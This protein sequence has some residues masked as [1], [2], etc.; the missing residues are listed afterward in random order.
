MVFLGAFLAGIVAKASV[1]CILPAAIGAALVSAAAQSINNYYDYDVDRK[2]GRKQRIPRMHILY[3]SLSLYVVGV[4][5]TV[6]ASVLHFAL[7]ALS[8]V[9]T[10]AYSA[11]LSRK[12]YWGNIVVAFFTAFVFV[13]AA[14]CGDVSRI[15]FPAFLAFLATWAREV[16]K[17][18]EDLPADIGHKVTLPMLVGAEMASYFAAYLVLLAVFFSPFPG[19]WG[20]SIFSEWY[21][22][23][24][25][26]AD[27]LFIL[28][29]LY[30][31]RGRPRRAQQ[32]CKAGMFLALLAFTAGTLL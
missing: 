28:S 24:L 3:F 25:V 5:L 27:A 26:P 4:L 10:W 8:A 12:K 21:Y 23:L 29:A 16:M 15:L 17:D 1:S 31:I 9:G 14:L 32:L 2:K 22:Y 6:L 13:F 20:F 18:I 11:F 30:I 7:A 19:P